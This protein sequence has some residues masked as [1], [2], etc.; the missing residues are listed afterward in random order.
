MALR[1]L[2]DHCIS[3]YII[4]TLQSG[5]HEVL[6]LRNLL[7]VRSRDPV[8]GKLLVVEVDRIRIR[9]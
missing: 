9:Q 2:A 3:N 8:V 6:P 1:F 5:G 7:P 4:Q